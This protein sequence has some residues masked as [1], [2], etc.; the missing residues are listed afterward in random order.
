MRCG[1][2]LY[3]DFVQ[4]DILDRS[5]DNRE[6]TDLGSEHINLIGA[7]PYVAEQ[8]FDGIGGL[9]VSVHRGRER[10]KRQEVFFVDEAWPQTSP[11]PPRAIPHAHRS[12]ADRCVSPPACAHL[13][14]GKLIHLCFPRHRLSLASTSLFPA[15]S[16]PN[17]VK[18]MVASVFSP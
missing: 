6:T 1:A 4:T 12:R 16:T 14:A 9:N 8:T 10:I 5:P 3:R 11:R 7:L 2:S 17:A 18:M 13:A 15:K